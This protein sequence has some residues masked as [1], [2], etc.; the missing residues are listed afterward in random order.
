VRHHSTALQSTVETVLKRSGYERGC[1]GMARE[2]VPRMS[3]RKLV[4]N[5]NLQRLAGD[6]IGGMVDG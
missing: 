6:W 5:R 3:V 4:E 1:E 2:G